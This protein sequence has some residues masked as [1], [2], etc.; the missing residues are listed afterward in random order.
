MNSID[1]IISIIESDAQ[2]NILEAE[3]NSE[4]F[5]Q[6][7]IKD[8]RTPLEI[9][10]DD[11]IAKHNIVSKIRKG[12]EVDLEKAWIIYIKAN[13]KYFE[14]QE[15]IQ[16]QKAETLKEEEEPVDKTESEIL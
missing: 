4:L 16:K 2:N 9:L 1:S 8:E 10:Y 3:Q 15:T 12:G 5:E 14:L 6:I 13:N 11:M 7:V